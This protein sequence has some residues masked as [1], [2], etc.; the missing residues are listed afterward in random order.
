MVVFG[1]TDVLEQ[2]LDGDL[3]TLLAPADNLV[4]TEV[5]QVFWWEPADEPTGYRLRMV[6][7]TF[8]S[9]A[10]LVIDEEIEEG[11]TFE[12]TL[13]AGEYQW[14]VIGI[15]SFSETT[16]VIRNLTILD[17]S[18]QN[19]SNQNVL[20]V[21]PVDDQVQSDSIVSFLWQELDFASNYRIQIATPDFSNSS[22]ITE[23]VIVEVDN[24]S[25]VLTD[26]EYQWRVRGEN[27]TSV[28]PYSTHSFFIDS[29]APSAPILNTPN[30][31]DTVS[32]PVFLGWSIDESS[33]QDTLYIYSDS[34][35]N[36]LIIQIGLVETS[37]TFTNPVL[38][39]Y[40]WRLRS[41]DAAGNVSPFSPVR[42][43]CVD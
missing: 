27:E 40:F 31:R 26:S 43:F 36:N 18:T 6:S 2:D 7:P 21:S 4:T 34:L 33:S 23:D 37:Y 19:L 11:V 8:D 29:S 13:P 32:A 9:I 20:L 28:T 42:S 35:L 25:T 14:T 22:F 3:I 17:D 30:D 41:V 10:R 12:T 16:P 5:S 1:C 39:K 24:Y 15:N 38:D